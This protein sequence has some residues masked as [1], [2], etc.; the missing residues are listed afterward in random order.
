MEGKKD[1]Y[2]IL[3]SYDGE[4]T[5]NFKNDLKHGKGEIIYENGDKFIG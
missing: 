3:K 1:G 2:G 4:Y 5:G